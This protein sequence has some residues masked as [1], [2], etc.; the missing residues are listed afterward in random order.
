M[1]FRKQTIPSN[2]S[3]W[4]NDES[5]I[6]ANGKVNYGMTFFVGLHQPSDAWP[7]RNVMVSVNRLAKRRGAFRVNDWIMDSG[8]FTEL[9]TFGRWRTE[10]AQY[11]AQVKRWA[12]NGNMVAAASQDYMCEPFILEKTGLSVADHQRL[13]IE[14]YRALHAECGSIILPVIQGFDPQDYLSHVA[15]YG[16]LLRPGMWV[17][18]GSVCKRNS[19][20]DSVE[21]VLRAIKAAR[22]DL[23][24]HGFGLK[25]TALENPYI[26]SMLHSSDSMA[27]SHCE[28]SGSGDANDPR[29]A[30]RYCAR[31][32]TIINTKTLYQDVLFNMWAGQFA[33]KK[34]A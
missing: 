30:L 5:F 2:T 20:P 24:L 25:I 15:Q 4:S 11:A 1:N 8:A 31:V 9:S 28:R 13:T 34:P 18:V 33:K 14:R 16:P 21:D 22:P 17:G 26:R 3:K 7:F 10:P 19:S 29:A 27:W 32:Q 23:R 12:T 6:L